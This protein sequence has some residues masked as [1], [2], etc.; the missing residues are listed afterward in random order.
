MDLDPAQRTGAC[1]TE[2]GAS[3][4]TA[5]GNPAQ[6]PGTARRR[7]RKLVRRPAPHCW[8]GD[9]S[10]PLPPCLDSAAT[11][12]V[13]ALCSCPQN[14]RLGLYFQS[15]RC[16]EFLPP[17]PGMG[18]EM[19]AG[20]AA[21]PP[22]TQRCSSQTHHRLLWYKPQLP[23]THSEG[24][25]SIIVLEYSAHARSCIRGF[26]DTGT[27]AYTRR[28]SF[29]EKPGIKT[30]GGGRPSPRGG[31]RH[32]WPVPAAHKGTGRGRPP[33]APLQWTS[34]RIVTFGG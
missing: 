8:L 12:V 3:E 24:A 5:A 31:G 27:Y 15:V 10:Q 7:P 28:S 2:R 9:A 4:P 18:E 30:K 22:G 6:K 1:G 13:L 26:G 20:S 34:H 21:A 32:A 29:S 25:A 33:R 16:S 11:S 23:F 14:G 17:Q 19:E